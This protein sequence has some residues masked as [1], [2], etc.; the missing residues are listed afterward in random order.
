MMPVKAIVQDLCFLQSMQPFYLINLHLILLCCKC[1]LC[2]Y[3]QPSPVLHTISIQYVRT[4][5]LLLLRLRKD[6]KFVVQ[7]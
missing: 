5:L 6:A 3:T 4:E 1:Y 2:M 7:K